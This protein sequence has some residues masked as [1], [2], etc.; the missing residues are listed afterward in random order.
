MADSTEPVGE[1]DSRFSSPGAEAVPWAVARE[2]LA[3]AEVYWL[4]TARADGR[5]HV[6]PLIGVWREGA[7]HFCTGPTEQKA[8][9]LAQ[10]PHCVLTTGGNTLGVG[11]DLVVEGEARRITEDAELR[12]LAACYEEKYGSAWRFEVGDG[13]FLGDGGR[14]LVFGVR[15][16]KVFG[17]GKGEPFSQTRWRP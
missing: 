6:T 8:H 15:P 14:A 10:S 4:A 3:A 13:V 2:A 9:N 16:T 11:L 12:E 7:L 5:P 17:F 1:L